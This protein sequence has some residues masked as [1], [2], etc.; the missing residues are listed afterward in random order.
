MYHGSCSIKNPL[1]FRCPPTHTYIHTY[2][3]TYIHT[4]T[5]IHTHTSSRQLLSPKVS[6]VLG[7]TQQPMCTTNRTNNRRQSKRLGFGRT[8]ALLLRLPSRRLNCARTRVGTRSR[9]NSAEGRGLPP[10]RSTPVAF[11]SGGSKK[12]GPRT[13]SGKDTE[14]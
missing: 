2:M 6:K 11:V 1:P 7:L 9:S 4:H 3:H 8:N 12:F 14:I 13:S 10:F 5:H